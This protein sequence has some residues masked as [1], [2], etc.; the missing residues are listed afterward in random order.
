[1][2]KNWIAYLEKIVY[3]VLSRA[4]SDRLKSDMPVYK[5]SAD[6]QYLEALGRIVCGIAPWLNLPKDV[7]TESLLREKYKALTIAAIDNLTN[8]GSRD[9]VDF[10]YGRQ[11]LVD[12]A[13]LSQGLLRGPKLWHEM[14]KHV[15]ENLIVSLKKTR[16]ITPAENNWLLFASMIEAFLL[17]YTNSCIYKRLNYGIKKFINN[18]YIGDGFYGD[19]KTLS[20]DH[21]N[22][23]VIQPMLTDI[24]HILNKHNIKKIKL[25]EKKHTLRYQRYIEILERMISPEGAYPLLGRTLVCRFGVFHALA[26]ASYLQILP[27][28]LKPAQVRC[29][30]D[31]VFK[32]HME[33]RSNFDADGFMT[34]GF[35]GVQ[36]NMAEVYVSSGSP[37]HCCTAFLPLG[38][39][40]DHEFWSQEICDWTSLKAFKGLEFPADHA[41]EERNASKEYLMT[42]VYKFQSLSLKIKNS[43]FKK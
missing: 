37:Y 40:S 17:E 33:T 1:M 26:Q 19:G 27:Y 2:R 4:A 36:H 24:L 5:D 34:I 7:S 39:E 31:A 3:P 15:Q 8:P 43:L 23:Y 10:G 20:M 18:Y 11:P 9:F 22:S 29:G 13:Y 35:N 32:R 14:P 21:Y 25:Y 38:L 42:F 16:L 6:F 30:L 41:Y 28:H 12:G